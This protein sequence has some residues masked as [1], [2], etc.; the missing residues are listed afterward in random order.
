MKR[1][2]IA[3]VI[4]AM[5]I[6]GALGAFAATVTV[7][8]T[9]SVDLRVWRRISDGELFISTRPH[10]AEDWN[11]LDQPLDMS[12]LSQSG[13]FQLSNQVRVDVPVLV[14]IDVPDTVQTGPTPR[15][16]PTVLP[17]ETPVAGPCCEV[18]GMETSPAARQQVVDLMQG[19]VDFAFETYEL[20]HA[21]QITIHISHSPNGLRV[22][23]EETFGERLDELP[24][25]CVFQEGSHIFFSPQC[26]SDKLAV[27]S[28]WFARS[29][30]PGEVNPTW[31][32]HGVRDYFAHHFADGVVPV[33]TEDRFRRVQFYERARD[34]RR[35]QASDDLMTLAMLYAIT[36]YG[37]FAD[38]LRFYGSVVSGLE[39]GFAF[40]SVF[41]ATLERFYEDFEQWMDH[42]K[43]V[44]ISTAFSS[45]QDA[46]ESISPQRDA[47]GLSSG[48]PDYRVPLEID[49]DEDGI[50]CEGFQPTDQ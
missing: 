7:E 45:C 41:S 25:D 11:T 22:R 18:E 21:G 48:F 44:L 9:A 4:A 2:I 8:E 50:V 14:D 15:P 32:G 34:I 40:E 49:D 27:A 3:A 36:E 19:V 33:I 6:G 17:S 29:L 26:R 46:S 1:T 23:Y 43:I 39:A 12:G 38:W 20:T 42:Q 47:S 16:A 10:G 5:A 35:D 28:A 37:D 13:R 30:G 24:D 31:I